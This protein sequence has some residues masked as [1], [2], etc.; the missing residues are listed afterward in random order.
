MQWS[1]QFSVLTNS[2][3]V[4]YSTKHAKK[5]YHPI[6]ST[7][8]ADDVLQIFQDHGHLAE[9]FWPPP[10]VISDEK[11]T[12]PNKTEFCIE[13]ARS[14]EPGSS[15]SKSKTSIVSRKQEK[16]VVLE[17]S[18]PLGIE[19]GIVH[20]VISDL[21]PGSE[22]LDS[23]QQISTSSSLYL[24]VERSVTAPK[25]LSIIVQ[26]TEGLV[27]KTKNLVWVLDEMG[28]NGKDLT[29]ALQQLRVRDGGDSPEIEL[30]KN[31]TE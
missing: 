12:T 10:H 24:E 23:L 4:L 30:R 31:K 29:A 5:S 6:P 9:I 22:A 19:L 25:P 17:E 20:R 7:L 3:A 1:G 21:P 14:S 8:G 18:M 2:K 16:E 11:H 15:V 13:C 26:V 27:C 28:R